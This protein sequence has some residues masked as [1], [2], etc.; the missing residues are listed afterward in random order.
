MSLVEKVSV[1]KP[2]V[3]TLL[4]LTLC[5]LGSGMVGGGQNGGHTKAPFLGLGQQ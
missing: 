1:L 2:G 3:Y 5:S 4:T